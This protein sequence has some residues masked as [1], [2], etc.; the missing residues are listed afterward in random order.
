MRRLSVVVVALVVALGLL[1]GGALAAGTQDQDRTRT[2][3]QT[4][5]QDCSGV[6]I[7]QQ[8]R[9]RAQEDCVTVSSCLDQCLDYLYNFLWGGPPPHVAE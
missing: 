7:Q 6:Q 3:A 9:D 5:D 4:C 2:C 8:D 1:A